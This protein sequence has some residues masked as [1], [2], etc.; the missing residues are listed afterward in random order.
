M[1]QRISAVV[2]FATVAALVVGASPVH[3][4]TANVRISRSSPYADCETVRENDINYL[5]AETEP[6]VASDP[7]D[8]DNLIAVWQ[9]DRWNHGA[10]RGLMAGYSMDGGQTWSRSTLPFSS[11]APG[12]APYDSASDPWVSIGPDGTAYAVG[13]SITHAGLTPNAI[14]AATSL[15]GGATWGHLRTI[16]AD[17]NGD[18]Y[19]NDKE[20]VTADPLIP[21]TAYVV[22]DR[23]RQSFNGHYRIPSL[24]SRTTDFGH[25]WSTPV[26]INAN[27]PDEQGLNNIIVVDPNTGT[28]F[29]FY[30]I[31]PSGQPRIEFVKSLD[32][33]ATWSAAKYV[34]ELD[35]V[36]VY[37]PDTFR[38][39]RTADFGAQVAMA[40]DG[41]IYLAWQSYLFNDRSDSEIAVMRSTN[42]GR[43]W[44]NPHR[45]NTDLDGQAFN[46][47][48]AVS[49]DGTLGLAYYDFRRDGQSET[50][51]ATDFWFR[52]STDGGVTFSDDQ[53]V[54]GRFDFDAAPKSGSARFIG[55]YFG[56]TTVGTTFVSVFTKTNCLDT[57]CPS[58]RTDVYSARLEP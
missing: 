38:F 58:N 55:D 46:P 53:H 44:S 45:G 3:A 49:E 2:G 27:G 26:V 22:W 31:F 36:G 40:S 28:L 9:Q 42:H 14:T 34:I 37:D 35:Y 57:S 47:S 41:T 16:K 20:T 4:G 25:D 51:L 18:I 52:T 21:G 30:T 29:D 8:P 56:M 11:C 6:M 33:G 24:F 15:D 10:S 50:Q 39:V 1:H 19:F 48:I 17:T 13:L 43:T 54:A 12:G 5:N 7:A 23:S 32:G